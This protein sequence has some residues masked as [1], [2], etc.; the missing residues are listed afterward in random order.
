MGNRC[1]LSDAHE[2]PAKHKAKISFSTKCHKMFLSQSKSAGP[3]MR[4][5][6]ARDNQCLLLNSYFILRDD[7]IKCRLDSPDLLAR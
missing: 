5:E 3:D 7:L 2:I 4:C 6:R 1:L